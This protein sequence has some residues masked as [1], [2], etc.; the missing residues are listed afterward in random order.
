MAPPTQTGRPSP[1]S[2]SRNQ[3]ERLCLIVNPRAGAGKVQRRLDD[4][5]R[6]ADRV[7]ENWEVR[8]TEGP[9]H[10]TEVA[11]NALTEGFDV[12]AA[13]GGDGTCNEVVNGFFAA[14]GVP[15]GEGPSKAIFTVIPLG[16]GSDLIRS[17]QIPK[18]TGEAMWVAST[19]ITLPADVVSATMVDPNGAPVHRYCFNVAGFGSNGEVVMRANRTSK[20]VGGTLTFLRA[21]VETVITYRPQSIALSWEGLDGAGS[22][23]GMLQAGFLGNGH[24]C[25]GGMWIGRGGSMF[26]GLMDILIL[27]PMNP[28]VSAFHLPK[29]YT[30]EMDKVPGVLKASVHRFE[31]IAT[32]PNAGPVL[33]DIDGE[34]PGKL[35]FAASCMPGRLQV[36]G[37]WLHSPVPIED[38]SL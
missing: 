14:G 23:E 32:D 6:C 17:L 2:G 34:Q 31:A 19:G 7:F 1:D 28:L 8:L 27:P 22:W 3:N 25:G 29:L 36:R 26:D 9:G 38:A 37:G 18:S 16:T 10:A 13:V 33:V 35:P 11:R 4:L 15:L 30:G 21:T 24:Y 12:L 20:R 5:R